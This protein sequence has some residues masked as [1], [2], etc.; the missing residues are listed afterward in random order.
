MVRGDHHGNFNG[1]IFWIELDGVELPGQ[2]GIHTRLSVA[3]CVVWLRKRFAIP[4]VSAD[5]QTRFRL[6]TWVRLG[7]R[8]DAFLAVAACVTR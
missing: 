8:H 7:V 3:V 1:I 4:E 2:G 6:Q 5:A